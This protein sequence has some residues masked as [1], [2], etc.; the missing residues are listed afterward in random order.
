MSSDHAHLQ[1]TSWR[2]D[3]RTVVTRFSSFSSTST[4]EG[5]KT[6]VRRTAVSYRILLKCIR[7]KSPADGYRVSIVTPWVT[8]ETMVTVRYPRP[9]RP[10]TPSEALRLRRVL[11]I[12][13]FIYSLA[14]GGNWVISTPSSRSYLSMYHDTYTYTEWLFFFFYRTTHNFFFFFFFINCILY[15]YVPCQNLK[16]FAL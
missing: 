12:T 6:L 8:R 3:R 9:P 1:Y 4:A 2:D 5:K 16:R 7:T 14:M 10:P 13:I 15:T 11:V